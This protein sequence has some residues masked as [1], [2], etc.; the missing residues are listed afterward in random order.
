MTDELS[1]QRAASIAEFAAKLRAFAFRQDENAPGCMDHVTKPA[2][3]AAAYA[4]IAS[5]AYAAGDKETA[6]AARADYVAMLA[7]HPSLNG[8]A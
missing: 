7:A 2:H 8:V 4:Q 5:E 1:I 6:K 3:A